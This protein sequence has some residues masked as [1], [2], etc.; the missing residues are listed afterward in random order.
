MIENPKN[1]PRLAKSYKGFYPF[2]LATT[3]FIYP[4][5]YIPNVKMLGPFV[6]EIELLL[7]E[8]H[9]IESL[10]PVSVVDQLQRLAT[11]LNFSY[12]IHLP[13]DIAISVHDV[14][15]Q[16]D[17]VETFTGIIQ[18]LKPLA[19]SLFCL[20]VPY[21]ENDN[22]TTTINAWRDRVRSNME[23]L[24]GNGIDPR[25]IS[26]ETLDYP[27]ELIEDIV[28][29]L[30]LSICMDL[31]HLILQGN[32]IVNVFNRFSS[33]LSVIHL[34]GV[35]GNRDHLSLDRL[36]QQYINPIIEIL[37]RFTGI[38][39]LEVFSYTHL[40]PSLQ[41]LETWWNNFNETKS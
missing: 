4:D 7:F 36:P 38:V 18:R 12:N 20:H 22:Q 26:I 31:G 25:A 39:S 3:S 27:L 24:L 1:Y 10:F 6:D 37:K 40:K 14:R 5:D 8:S 9:D 23:Y 33:R 29:D 17:A 41:V 28:A 13:T 15:Q 32:D 30:N 35:E 11:D 16:Q 19:P 21:N 34:H 2:K